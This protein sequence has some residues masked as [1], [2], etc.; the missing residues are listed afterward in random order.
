MNKKEYMTELKDR[1]R[2]LPDEEIE[3]VINYYEEYFDDAGEENE[4]KTI[5]ALGSPAV[6]ASKIIGEYA[7]ND[8]KE[9][10]ET[11]TKEGKKSHLTP[12]WITILAILASPIALP[13]V[14]S[15]IVILIAVMVVIFALVVSGIAVVGY[16]LVSVIFSFLAY[17]YGFANGILLLGSGL[18]LLAIG[19]AMTIAFVKLSRVTIKGL[20]KWFGKILVRRGS[21]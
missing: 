7:I 15:L 18:L 21:K 20:Q 14:I 1:L 4:E 12:L 19:V 11:K 16:G 2:R 9:P 8:V 17:T 3:N 5:E 13:I 6:V 10:K